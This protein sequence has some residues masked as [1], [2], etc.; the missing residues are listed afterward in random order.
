[1][2]YGTDYDPPNTNFYKLCDFSDANTEKLKMKKSWD[3][4]K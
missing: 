4:Q 1:M 3:T 2:L